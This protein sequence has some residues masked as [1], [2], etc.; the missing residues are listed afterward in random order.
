M[1]QQT[2]S[3]CVIGAGNMAQA[4]VRGA[5]DRR[6]LSPDRLIVAEPDEA[7][8]S[9][10]KQWR[11]DAHPD[12]ASAL[13]VIPHDA[14][15]MLAVKPQVF[16]VVA[17]DL[18]ARIDGRVVMSIM[19]GVG[20]E[21]I[22]RALGDVRV[23]RLMPNTPAR[24]AKGI[25]AI[26]LGAGAR[27]GDDALARALFE[28]VGALEPVDE[29]LMDAFTAIAGSGPAYVFYLA[30]AMTRA[31]VKAGFDGQAAARIVRATIAG[32]GALLEASDQDASALR[33]AVTSRG[34]TTAAAV[35]VLDEHAIMDAIARAVFAA[36]DRAGEL[37]AG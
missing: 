24:L 8:R 15:L 20:T 27:P 5:L 17:P 28:A 34:G 1:S 19:A 16:D 9:L 13:D 35:A 26:C 14:Q 21:R 12:V 22:R 23:I 29:S 37:G 31:G 11:A 7:T 18:H 2:P 32:A 25:T 3:L 36:R 6:V 30:E 10:W 4:I 33:A